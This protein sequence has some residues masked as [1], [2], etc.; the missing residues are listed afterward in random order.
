MDNN[1]IQSTL[2]KD[3]LSASEFSSILSVCNQKPAKYF[4]EL[5][6]SATL[7]GKLV[8]VHKPIPYISSLNPRIKEVCVIRDN[9]PI[10]T[11]ETLISW[12]KAKGFVLP[13][14]CEKRDI[15][16]SLSET[17]RN[18]LLEI[19]LGMAIYAFKY[20]PK[21]TRNFAT[22]GNKNSIRAAL[23]TSGL[24]ADEDTIRGYL[25]E[26]VKLFENKLQK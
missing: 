15:R 20:D 23:Q 19:L 22:G 2:I 18:K 14:M 5:I 21:A 16:C 13:E 9:S 6:L 25:D 12:A 26:A 10:Y 11:T 4:Q 3:S 1:F 17:E 8:P 24:D 7:A